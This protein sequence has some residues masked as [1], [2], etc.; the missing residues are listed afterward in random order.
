MEK[1]KCEN[2]VLQKCTIIKQ[3][4]MKNICNHIADGLIKIKYQF[5]YLYYFK[6]IL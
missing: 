5:V 6:K 1:C 3:K 4:K 2:L